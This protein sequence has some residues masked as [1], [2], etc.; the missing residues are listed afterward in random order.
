MP[1]INIKVTLKTPEQTINNSY[2]AI[3]HP[4]LQEIVYL[5]DDKT[6]TTVQ[7]KDSKIQRENANL[8]MEYPFEE[9]NSTQGIIKIKDLNKSVLVNIR[10]KKLIQENKNIEIEY[11][12]ENE[13]YK[14]I[15]EEIEW[16]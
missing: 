9:Q 10:T 1:K 5:E 3:F 12:L 15:L 4:E 6:K 7:L 11:E 14:Y 8:W 2:K 16:V 13:N